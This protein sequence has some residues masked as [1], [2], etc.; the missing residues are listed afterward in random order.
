ML[1]L[2]KPSGRVGKPSGMDRF[3]QEK[4]DR[5]ERIDLGFRSDYYW[6]VWCADTTGEGK[7]PCALVCRKKWETYESVQAGSRRTRGGNEKGNTQHAA[8]RSTLASFV[9]LFVTVIE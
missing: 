5:S 2:R 7:S 8:Q 4:L 9:Y 6:E 1:R 3:C